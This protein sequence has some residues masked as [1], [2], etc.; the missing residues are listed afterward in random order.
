[1]APKKPKPAPVRPEKCLNCETPLTDCFC[2]KCGQNNSD[3]R[4]HL[5][6]IAGHLMDEFLEFDLPFLKTI[7][8][9]TIRPGKVCLEYTA[10]FRKRYSN[11]FRY[12]LLMMAAYIFLLNALELGL[13]K[14][15]V[16]FSG[17]PVAEEERT[18]FIELIEQFPLFVQGHLNTF[19][20]LA[21]PFVA[22]ALK[23]IS[24]RAKLNYA[25][26]YVFILFI[27]GQRSV[28][29]MMLIP[30]A[31]IYDINVMK[32]AI[33]TMSFLFTTWGA[34]VFYRTNVLIGF[35]KTIVIHLTLFLVMLPMILIAWLL[36][37]LLPAWLRGELG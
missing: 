37:I 33:L 29:S 6:Q 13:V 2:P 9:L 12:C 3:E 5:S 20:F 32:T 35:L 22:L 26:H 1:M 36:F 11:P 28:F 10:G 16:T 18:R 8:Q 30:L 21:L 25:E 34:T 23:L 7:W 24:R 15:Q 4:L 17:Q 31:F 27:Y 14:G 19:M